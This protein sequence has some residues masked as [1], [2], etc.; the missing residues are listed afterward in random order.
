MKSI[1]YVQAEKTGNLLAEKNTKIKE[2][3]A[4]ITELE[5][6]C[7]AAMDWLNEFG[8]HA[9]ITFGGEQEVYDQLYNARYQSTGKGHLV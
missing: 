3:A 4:R 9:P 6:A 8:E 1:Q 2:Q 5:A 7:E